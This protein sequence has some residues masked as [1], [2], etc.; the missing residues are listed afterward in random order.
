MIKSNIIYQ[1]IVKKKDENNIWVRCFSDIFPTQKYAIDSAYKM[2]TEVFVF[3]SRQAEVEM[4]WFNGKGI[5]NRKIVYH[6]I[7]SE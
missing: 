2:V 7:K 1:V 3:G 5:I 4:I 6:L